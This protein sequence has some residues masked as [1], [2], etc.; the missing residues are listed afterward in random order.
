M[1]DSEKLDKI[2]NF[3]KSFE[4]IL[5]GTNNKK[6]LLTRLNL[7]ERNIGIL[8]IGFGFICTSIIGVAFWVIKYGFVG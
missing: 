2:L 5:H 8:G 3:H 1:T 6:G 4:I 7:A